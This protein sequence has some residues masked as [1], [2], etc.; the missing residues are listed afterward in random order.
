MCSVSGHWV[1]LLRVKWTPLESPRG[2]ATLPGRCGRAGAASCPPR[3]PTGGRRAPQGPVS[4]R[5]G[6]RCLTRLQEQVPCRWW[7]LSLAVTDRRVRGPA[8]GRC[9]LHQPECFPGDSVALVRP[10]FGGRD[11]LC[12]HIPPLPPTPH[13][14]EVEAV[15]CPPCPPLSPR[16]APPLVPPPGSGVWFLLQNTHQRL[17]ADLPCPG[18]GITA[19]CQDPSHSSTW[20]PWAGPRAHRAVLSA[21]PPGPRP[22]KTAGGRAVGQ[23]PVL[24]E[25]RSV[26]WGPGP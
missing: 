10:C 2:S 25:G 15:P 7:G 13:P 26:R 23:A 17:V 12:C 21:E 24:P 20:S 9:S 22:H 4:G 6:C 3:G 8:P 16:P 5:Q 19:T 11:S 18:S 14:P 1:L